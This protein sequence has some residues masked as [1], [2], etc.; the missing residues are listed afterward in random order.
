MGLKTLVIGASL[1]EDKYSN[2][3]VKL[4]TEYH[5]EVVAFGIKSGVISKVFIDTE[6]KDYKDI[7]TITMY[8]NPERQKDFYNYIINLKPRRVI[9][10]PGTEN[11]EFQ[12]LLK[13]EGI[14]FEEACTLVLLRTNQFEN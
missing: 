1:N 3:A 11:K 6:L 13:N 2:M 7:D 8:V 12:E 4:L 9:F 10:N 5:H 14:L